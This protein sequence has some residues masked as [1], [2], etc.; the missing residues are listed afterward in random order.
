LPLKSDTEFG[1]EE[2]IRLIGE[3]SREAAETPRR[4]IVGSAVAFEPGSEI[5]VF[6]KRGHSVPD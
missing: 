5:G 6:P 2:T 4:P 3:L 1:K